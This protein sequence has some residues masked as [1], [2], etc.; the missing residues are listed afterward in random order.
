MKLNLVEIPRVKTISKEDFYNNYVKKQK[1][2]VVEKLTEEWP[3]YKKWKLEYI[4][5]IAGDKVV[6][7]YDDRPVSH[8]DGFNEA[9]TKMKMSDY[10]NMMLK[11]PTN[12]RIFLYNLMNEV[13]L[14]QKDFKWP[15]IGLRLVK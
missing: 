4:K 15:N 13:P 6:P 1:P 9:H 12:Y 2:V 14:L 10:I 7:L 3:A 5:E 11:E 8:K